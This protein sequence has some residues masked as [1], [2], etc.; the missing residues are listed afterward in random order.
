MGL[1]SVGLALFLRLVLGRPPPSLWVRL[2]ETAVWVSVVVSL[3]G[4]V[5][6]VVFERAR[7]GS[8]QHRVP[9][10]LRDLVR[11]LLVAATAA[12]VYSFVWGRELTGAVAALGVTS[13]VVGLALQEPLG[14]LFR[15]DAPDG[16]PV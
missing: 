16:A 4:T 5:N 14:N 10:L 13:I 3:L 8:W 11:L 6:V 12:L 9:N 7:P 1:P 2:A 15:A